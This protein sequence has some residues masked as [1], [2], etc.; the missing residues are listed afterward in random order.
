M[1]IDTVVL[2]PRGQ[3]FARWGAL[4]TEELAAYNVPNPRTEDLWFDWA[5]SLF[6][7][8][9]LVSLGLPDPRGFPNWQAWAEQLVQGLNS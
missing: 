9:D 5:C 6:G 7:S 2:D 4:L 8:P 1:A 3:E